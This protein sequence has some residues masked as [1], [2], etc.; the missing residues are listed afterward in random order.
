MTPADPLIYLRDLRTPDHTRQQHARAVLAGTEQ[1]VARGVYLNAVAWQKLNPRERYV[2]RV[3]AFALT[4][5]SRPVLS[6]WSAAA[7]LGLPVLEGWPE[8]IHITGG[9][10]SGGRSRGIARVHSLTLTDED[11]VEV[12]GLLVTSIART[13]VDMAVAAEFISAV[14]I[15]DRALYT[16]PLGRRLPMVTMDQLEG[17]FERAR[18]TRGAAKVP[19]VLGAAVTQS[20]SVLETGS[21]VTMG[22]IG[23]PRPALQERFDDHAGL[24]GW[25]DFYWH[26]FRLIGEADGSIK[27]LDPEYRSGRTADQVVFGEKVR[28]DR[29]RALQRGVTRWSWKIGM[30]PVAL[31][32]HLVRAGLPMGAP[33]LSVAP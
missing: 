7:M 24:I 15:A 33:W 20:G 14:A 6:H 11:V 4:R 10:S 28:E 12:D 18:L 21:R 17:A 13:V 3:R 31:R 25:T 26:D 8:G 1:R 30:N 9:G 16:D 5:R 22:V 27:Y 23:C 19:V 32:A 29:L 2:T